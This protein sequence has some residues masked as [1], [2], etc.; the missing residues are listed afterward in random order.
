MVIP[1]RKTKEALGM[2]FS[3]KIDQISAQTLMEVF[4]VKKV[5]QSK[6]IFE[7]YDLLEIEIYLPPGQS[8]RVD[9]TL[10]KTE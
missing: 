8:K 7:D 10:R 3:D 1:N 6:I 4:K 5:V 2:S 9:F